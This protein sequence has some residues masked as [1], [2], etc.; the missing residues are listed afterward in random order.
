MSILDGEIAFRSLAHG[1]CSLDSGGGL[2]FCRTQ[3]A[4]AAEWGVMQYL[5]QPEPPLPGVDWAAE[6][7]VLLVC[8]RRPTLGYHVTIE[9]IAVDGTSIEVRA[10]ERRPG[11]DADTLQAL[12]NPFHAVA[13]GARSGAERLVLQIT[14]DDDER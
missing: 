4:W 2:F 5:K 7:V 11:P 6:M 9:S 14:Y 10:R 12:A 13:I 1:S 3:Q 8:G